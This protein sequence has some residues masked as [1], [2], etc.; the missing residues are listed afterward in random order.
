MN[1]KKLIART[2]LMGPVLAAILG[3][4]ILMRRRSRAS[5]GRRGH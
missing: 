2:F 4:G 1:I 3:V 5:H